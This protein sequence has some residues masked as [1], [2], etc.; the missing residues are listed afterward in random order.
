LRALADL[1][2]EDV[3]DSVL[4]AYGV[5]RVEFGPEYWIRKPLDPRV[6]L[7]IACFHAGGSYVSED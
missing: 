6:P 5:E 4:R 1:A 2:K 3:P 7:R